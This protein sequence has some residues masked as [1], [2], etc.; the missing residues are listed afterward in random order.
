MIDYFEHNRILI[1]G[2]RI[3]SND[4]LYYQV[5][6]LTCD[7]SNSLLQL[8]YYKKS[9]P[10]IEKSLELMANHPLFNPT[11]PIG[12]KKRLIPIYF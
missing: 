10:V 6:R 12:L 8:G 11:W 9:L 5:T 3:E 2:Q 4:T 7:Y 1:E